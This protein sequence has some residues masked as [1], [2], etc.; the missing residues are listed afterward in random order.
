MGGLGECSNEQQVGLGEHFPFEVLESGIADEANAM[1]GLLT[2]GR[3]DLRHDA[4]Q[5]RIHEARVERV[6][7]AFGGEIQNGDAKSTHARPP[8]WHSGSGVRRLLAAVGAGAQT[9]LAAVE[10]R[11]R[12][13]LH[14]YVM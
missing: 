3:D 11:H 13:E 8:R 7:G 1:T 9:G 12:S 2:P 4:R 14:R 10:C 5:V 6:R